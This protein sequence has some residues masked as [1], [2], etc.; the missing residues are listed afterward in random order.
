MDESE[1]GYIHFLRTYNTD[2]EG[3]RII[4]KDAS[5]II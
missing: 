4:A 3:I 1:D 5:M 2:S